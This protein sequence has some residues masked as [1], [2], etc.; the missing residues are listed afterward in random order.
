MFKL[1]GSIA[2]STIPDPPNA[3]NWHDQVSSGERFKFGK[4]W[5]HFLNQLN[6]HSI[7]RSRR[8]F[9][10]MLDLDEL[11]GKRFVDVGSGSGLSSLIAR[12]NGATVVSFDFDPEC[13]ACT[14]EIRDRYRPNDTEWTIIEGSVLDS[15]FLD[16][17]A[18]FDVVYSWG[19][20]H[21]T[22]AMWLAIKNS[23]LLVEPEGYLFLSLYNDQGIKSSLWRKLKGLYCTNVFGRW[24]A[25]L[26]GLPL[27]SF[28]LMVACVIQR[29]NAFRDYKKKRGMSFYYDCIDWL[30]GY[31]YEVAKPE[32]VLRFVRKAGFELINMTTTNGHGTNQFVFR[33]NGKKLEN[34][35]TLN[36]ASRA[37]D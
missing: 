23:M 20:L 6:E 33:R 12:N 21:H 25:F 8:S 26:I 14:Q 36:N 27:L 35:T 9:D 29:T 1:N 10:E 18:R 5:R 17:L 31:P 13:V 37:T 15:D 3:S 7:E 24:L 22:G 2:H 30:G 32:E 16:G 19:V 34:D 4:N 28:Q 11:Q